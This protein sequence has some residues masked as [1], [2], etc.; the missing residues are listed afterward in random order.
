M[1]IHTV[2]FCVMAP[3][4]LVNGYS[5]DSVGVYSNT[6]FTSVRFTTQQR[7]AELRNGEVMASFE[8]IYLKER[9][10]YD[11]LQSLWPASG[12]IFES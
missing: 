11:K 10:K 9:E 3:F 6:A 4:S 2:V 7:V 1:K 12:S 8:I 5:R